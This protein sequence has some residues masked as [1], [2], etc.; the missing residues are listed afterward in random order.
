MQRHSK[1]F[2]LV[3]M[4]ASFLF[5]ASCAS[6]ESMEVSKVPE[7]N[8]ASSEQSFSEVESPKVEDVDSQ[9]DSLTS[10]VKD[11]AQS[12]ASNSNLLEFIQNEEPQE[13]QQVTPTE[14]SDPNRSD[15]VQE[16]IE[17]TIDNQCS[18]SLSTSDGASSSTENENGAPWEWEDGYTYYFLREPGD[19]QGKVLY[20]QNINKEDPNYRRIDEWV[21][22]AQ[23]FIP[24]SEQDQFFGE[25]GYSYSFDYAPLRYLLGP[26]A[27]FYRQNITEEDPDYGV[28]GQWD[29]MTKTYVT[30]SKWPEPITDWEKWIC[31]W[32][33]EDNP[34]Q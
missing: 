34:A 22:E 12:S 14:S 26:E 2:C 16:T 27:T 4:F 24:K 1:A 19:G 18:S 3:V 28:I 29:R 11:D 7:S 21:P 6:E 30:V 5:L 33:S 23:R 20:R 32:E 8:D 15:I 13:P 17:V 9:D 10:G 31:E 25:E